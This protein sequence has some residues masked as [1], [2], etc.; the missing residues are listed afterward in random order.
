MRPSLAAWRHTSTHGHSTLPGLKSTLIMVIRPVIGLFV[1]RWYMKNC[2]YEQQ[3]DTHEWFFILNIYQ[4]Y[5]QASSSKLHT[6]CNRWFSTCSLHILLPIDAQHTV[7]YGIAAVTWYYVTAN[8]RRAPH[9]I[10]HFTFRIAAY[11]P[12]PVPKVNGQLTDTTTHG[13]DDSWTGQL[14]D[15]TGDFACF[16]FIF[17][18]LIRSDYP[19]WKL[20]Q[21]GLPST[22]MGPYPGWEMP[23]TDESLLEQ[24]QQQPL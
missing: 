11:Y 14:A 5:P 17:R 12:Y 2:G 20:G 24:S 13:L 1:Y 22:I 23:E 19:S 10:P 21:P 3:H 18:T 8:H 7:K 6:F 9:S 16:V 4:Q 15:A